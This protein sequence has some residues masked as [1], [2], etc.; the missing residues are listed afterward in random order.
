MYRFRPMAISL[1]I[2]ALCRLERSRGHG[3]CRLNE[4][5]GDLG[6][7]CIMIIWKRS[8]ILLSMLRLSFYI[9]IYIFFQYIQ[10]KKLKKGELKGVS[11]G[12]EYTCNRVYGYIYIYIYW[13]ILFHFLEIYEG[14]IEQEIPMT[15]N[16]VNS[17]GIFL[18]NRA[19]QK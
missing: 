9:Y 4:L 13:K 2:V 7:V 12:Y 1:L 16:R 14:K 8:W 17:W 15:L 5:N 18:E 10:L 6:F 3:L 19:K 11:G